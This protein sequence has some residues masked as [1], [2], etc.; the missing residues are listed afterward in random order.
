MDGVSNYTP[1]GKLIVLI[2]AYGL[3]IGIVRYEPS[4]L[5]GLIHFELFESVLAVDISDDKIPV[6]GFEATIN[7]H[8]IPIEDAA[9][10]MES[11]STWV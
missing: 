2:D 4:A 10:R 8:D 1:N 5:A 3:E 7:D 9:S 6:L 11:P